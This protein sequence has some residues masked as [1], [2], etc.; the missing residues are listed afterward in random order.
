[1]LATQKVENVMALGTV[2]RTLMMTAK[3]N[4]SNASDHTHTRRCTVFF[5]CG[6]SET[7]ITKE[8]ATQ[9]GLPILERS[10]TT[11]HRFGDK[12]GSRMD[13]WRV[14]FDVHFPDGTRMT[15]EADAVDYLCGSIPTMAYGPG[16]VAVVLELS[17]EAV[18]ATMEEPQILIGLNDIHEFNLTRRKQRLPNGFYIYDSRVGPI[19]WGRGKVVGR[20]PMAEAHQVN[21]IQRIQSTESSYSSEMPNPHTVAAIVQKDQELQA[22][23]RLVQLEALGIESPDKVNEEEVVKER[24][25][26][27]LKRLPDG[28][29]EV[30]FP[31]RD[32]LLNCSVKAFLY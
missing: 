21:F 7:L 19:L 12:N 5:D 13:T 22:I 3:V 20:R 26:E 24:H 15:V 27:T 8:L 6:S 11:F 16:Q 23:E 30:S 29:Y 18:N 17:H 10:T 32:E 4:V 9:L 28:R 14:R 31:Y 2:K 25:R 1:M